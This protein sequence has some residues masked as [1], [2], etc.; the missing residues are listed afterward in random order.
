MKRKTKELNRAKPVEKRRKRNLFKYTSIFFCSAV[1][2]Y[3]CYITLRTFR[4]T[5]AITLP[6][7][8][9]II[10]FVDE[11]TDSLI[12]HENYH[13]HYQIETEG[14]FMFYLKYALGQ[15]CIYEAQANAHPDDHNVCELPWMRQPTED[16]IASKSEIIAWYEEFIGNKDILASKR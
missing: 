10:Y 14:A 9:G 5:E 6:E 7:P 12:A 4:N 1:A 13:L 15:G 11:P 16:Q 3:L 2:F 8:I